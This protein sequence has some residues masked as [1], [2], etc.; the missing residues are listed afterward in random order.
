MP[1]NLLRPAPARLDEKEPRQQIDD[2]GASSVPTGGR[3]AAARKEDL[4]IRSWRQIFAG[5]SIR[6][7]AV[8]LHRRI[9]DL[10]K[11]IRT[12]TRRPILRKEK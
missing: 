2:V 7:Q 12:L 1:R 11:S 4:E 5:A 9:H 10:Q 6:E 3:I 8:D